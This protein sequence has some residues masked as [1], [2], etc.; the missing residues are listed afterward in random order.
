MRRSPVIQPLVGAN[1]RLSLQATT[2]PDTKQS[3]G[4]SNGDDY[5][6]T[7]QHELTA[8]SYPLRYKL[9]S[10]SLYARFPHE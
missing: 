1:D 4:G 7:I 8:S 3:Y 6:T 10:R 2:G 9:G 5:M